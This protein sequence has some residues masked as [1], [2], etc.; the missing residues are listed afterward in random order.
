MMDNVKRLY[1]WEQQEFDLCGYRIRQATYKSITV[2]QESYAWKIGFITMSA[3]RR[4]HMS[5]TLSEEEHTTL[6]AKRGEL[7]SLATKTMIQ[8]LAPLRSVSTTRRKQPQDKVSR[9]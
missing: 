3:H 9:I 6:L 7:N 2:D 1:A 5:E 4:K 8:L